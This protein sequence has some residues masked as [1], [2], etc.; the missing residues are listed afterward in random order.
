MDTHDVAA[1][2]GFPK[3]GEPGVVVIFKND[4]V[5]NIHKDVRFY[6]EG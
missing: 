2:K 6:Y 5:N 3:R 1:Y 4:R